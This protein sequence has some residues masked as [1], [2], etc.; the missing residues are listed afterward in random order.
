FETQS[1]VERM[2]KMIV[3]MAILVLLPTQPAFASGNHGGLGGIVQAVINLLNP[4]RRPA[5]GQIITWNGHR[6][7][8]AHYGRYDSPSDGTYNGEQMVWDGHH[9]IP[10]PQPGSND[11]EI[12]AGFG[13]L[14][15]GEANGV[16]ENSGT[17]EVNAGSGP[18]Q[19]PFI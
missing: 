6:W 1:G 18:G 14:A 7:V 5:A 10:R 13:L 12:T 11:I 4:T 2:K 16:I 8:P 17:L 3:L 19:V 9:W 15:N